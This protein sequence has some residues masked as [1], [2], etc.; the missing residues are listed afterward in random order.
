MT[1]RTMLT[2]ALMGRWAMHVVN[3]KGAFLLGEFDDGIEIHMEIPE[4]FE[5]WYEHDEL[6]LLLQT[7][8]GIKQAAMAFWRE[9]NKAMKNM[10]FKQSAIDP[11]LFYRWTDHGLVVIWLI[12]VN[13]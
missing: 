13:D 7:I 11:C 5:Q 6:W 3:V 10:G 12:W 1:V 2:I 9:V 4:G 8:Y